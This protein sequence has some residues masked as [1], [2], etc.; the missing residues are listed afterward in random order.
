MEL[1][2]TLFHI[3]RLRC[4]SYEDFKD[5]DFQY[6]KNKIIFENNKSYLLSRQ[7]IVYNPIHQ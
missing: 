7:F 3:Y 6:T 4:I 1:I 2:S 5:W